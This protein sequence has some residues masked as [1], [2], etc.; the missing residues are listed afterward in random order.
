M[1]KV[2]IMTFLKSVR[3]SAA[4][5]SPVDVIADR[6]RQCENVNSG[7]GAQKTWKRYI[8]RLARQEGRVYLAC[9]QKEMKESFQAGIQE[10]TGR[11][12]KN[13]PDESHDPPSILNS[14]KFWSALGFWLEN[15]NSGGFRM[16]Q[17]SDSKV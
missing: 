15:T 5:P 3:N 2:R 7:S 12:L 16:C 8:I 14:P 6:N 1:L 10:L 17:N 4:T 13:S 9:F 11:G